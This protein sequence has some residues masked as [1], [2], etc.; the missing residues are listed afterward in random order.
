MRIVFGI[1]LAS[2]VS[3]SAYSQQSLKNGDSAPMFSAASL[4]GQQYDLNGLKGKV[5]V[6]TFWSTRCNIC[7]SEIPKLNRLADRFKGQD[8][9]FLGLTTD[10]ESKVESYLRSTPFQFNILPNSFGVL[11]QYA[12]R[13][14]QGNIDMGFPAYF[15]LDQNGTLEY[16]A[17]GWDK[18]SNLDSNIGKL[19]G[20]ARL[21]KP[22]SEVKANSPR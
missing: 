15:V 5:V 6:I 13:D 22:T 17:S 19:L 7:H 18:T 12:D 4:N 16:R 21:E 20:S 3:I 8:V 10:N 14:R 9:V 2:L 1:I 11:L